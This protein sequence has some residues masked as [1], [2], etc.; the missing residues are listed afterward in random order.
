MKAHAIPVTIQEDPDPNYVRVPR[1]EYLK[2]KLAANGPYGSSLATAKLVRDFHAE[3]ARRLRKAIKKALKVFKDNC[4]DSQC[5]D[6]AF[7]PYVQR[8][9]KKQKTTDTEMNKD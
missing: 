2:Q 1:S 5:S 7:D 8:T 3:E 4:L 9:L 6:E